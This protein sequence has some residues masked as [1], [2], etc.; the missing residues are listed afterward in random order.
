MTLDSSEQ[1]SKCKA[2]Q[3]ARLECSLNC[4]LTSLAASTHTPFTMTGHDVGSPNDSVCA[5]VILRYGPGSW[6]L[7]IT[8]LHFNPVQLVFWGRSSLGVCHAR[9]T[10]ASASHGTWTNYWKHVLPAWSDQHLPLY[11][12]LREPRGHPSARIPK[13][14]HE[15]ASP[16]HSLNY[17]RLYFRKK[18][19]CVNINQPYV[20]KLLPNP[21]YP[22][23]LL[24]LLLLLLFLLKGGTSKNILNSWTSSHAHI[25]YE[26]KP[27]VMIVCL[28][29]G[30]SPQQGLKLKTGIQSRF[31]RETILST[32]ANPYSQL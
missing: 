9:H 11:G 8:P 17:S 28:C 16:S 26:M 21:A 4:T 31:E 2:T 30:L 23:F 18:I 22:Y 15:W 32:Y 10:G 19:D 13:K 24:F 27:S 14:N 20:L 7:K 12:S 6:L 3:N 5:G 1:R 29:F 25:G